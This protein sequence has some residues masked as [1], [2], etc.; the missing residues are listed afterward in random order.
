MTVTASGNGLD[1]AVANS[2]ATFV[3]SVQN[4]EG[5]GFST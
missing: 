5:E 4:A 1:G 2:P 3:I